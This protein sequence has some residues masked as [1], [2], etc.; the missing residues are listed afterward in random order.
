M[1]EAEDPARA[2][3]PGLPPSEEA[4]ISGFVPDFTA[5]E[6]EAADFESGLTWDE[7]RLRAAIPEPFENAPASPPADPRP[8]DAAQQEAA[9]FSSGK[10]R[11]E[12]AEEAFRGEHRRNE[13][14]RNHFEVMAICALWITAFAVT[15]IGSVWLLHMV[16]PAK[17]RWLSSE[18]LSH[19]Q[20]IV[21]AGLL[22]GVI[23]N[24]F[25]K[26]LN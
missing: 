11:D 14:F 15:G 19:I 12:L 18:D 16:L 23:G 8:L 7:M 5:A 4:A 17:Y 21:T 22:V 1:D 2:V 10:S 24:H 9:D 3:I 6:T 26:R 20:S 25:K 13:K